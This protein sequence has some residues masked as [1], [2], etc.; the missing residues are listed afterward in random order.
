MPVEATKKLIKADWLVLLKENWT[1]GAPL[2]YIYVTSVGMVQAWLQF[3]A[4]GI[5]IFEFSEISDFLLMAFRV[6]LSFLAI[7]GI[8]VYGLIG[9]VISKKTRYLEDKP[10]KNGLQR[11]Q[12]TLHRLSFIVLGFLFIFIAPYYGP[13]LFHNDYY[14]EWRENILSNQN[15]KVKV[16]FKDIDKYDS[17]TGWF[18]N[19]ILIGT[20]GKFAFFFDESKKEIIT[21]PLST[22]L[23]IK[24]S[25]LPNE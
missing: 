12:Y 16:I 1:W 24:H 22:V 20:T 10:F 25:D 21:A 8:A 6:P 15:R 7:L 5:N 9:I 18:D 23:L 3:R 11:F 19:L 13:K 2:I 17:K 14:K 4:F